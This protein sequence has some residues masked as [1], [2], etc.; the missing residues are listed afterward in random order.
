MRSNR[1]IQAA[2]LIAALIQAAPATAVIF[3]EIDTFEDG[4]TEN[5]RVPPI[6]PSPPQNVTDG[7]PLGAGDNFM[8][9]TSL[10]GP[11]QGVFPG[12]RLAV[13]NT[14]QWTG[15]YIAAGVDRITMDVRNFGSVPLSLWLLL[16]SA[17]NVPPGDD[18]A[19]SSV[20]VPLPAMSDWTPVEFPIGPGDLT[21]LEGSVNDAL[22]NVNQ[23]WLFHHFAMQPEFPPDPIAATLGVDNIRAGSAAAAVIP[24]P[25]SF[26]V[27]GL[28]ALTACG[29]SNLR[30]SR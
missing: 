1:F 2:T 9:L 4:T 21:A 20:A 29:L 16:S 30:R 17:M 26:V 23:L 12:S 10:G 22:M 5:W 13:F 24:E 27:W 7:G 25:W 3:G 28:L 8:L 11:P 15:N 19:V 14:D 6:H 18:I